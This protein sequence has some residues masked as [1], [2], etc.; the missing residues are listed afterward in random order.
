MKTKVTGKTNIEHIRFASSKQHQEHAKI[1][2]FA[3]AYLLSRNRPFCFCRSSGPSVL[4]HFCQPLL[5]F[6]LHRHLCPC[7]WNLCL[8]C[9]SCLCPL[10]AFDLTA[11]R[12]VITP[13]SPTQLHQDTSLRLCFPPWHLTPPSWA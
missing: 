3:F 11:V 9:L 2:T 4:V 12:V 8:W 1:M 7:I 5:N 6:S 13:L 10:W